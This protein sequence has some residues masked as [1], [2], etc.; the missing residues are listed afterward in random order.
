MLRE[1]FWIRVE[2]RLRMLQ[3]ILL[4]KFRN[5]G[6]KRKAAVAGKFTGFR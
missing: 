3:I 6:Q 2:D 5:N 4:E 1:K